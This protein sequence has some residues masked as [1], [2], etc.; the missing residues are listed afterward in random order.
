MAAEGASYAE[1]AAGFAARKPWYPTTHL[2]ITMDRSALYARLDDRVDAMIS[3]GLLQE[4]TG[5]LDRGLRS[6]LTAQQAIGYKELVPVVDGNVPLEAAI[7][8]IKR[9]TRRYAKRQLTWFRADPRVRWVDVTGLSDAQI[10]EAAIRLL[11]S[12]ELA[13]R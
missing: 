6:A 12:D 13:P 3:A 2:G 11:E 10:T 5:L 9:A 8:D 1:Q 7:A 4:V